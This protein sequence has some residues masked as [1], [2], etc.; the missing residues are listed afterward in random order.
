MLKE[1]TKLKYPIST[2][3][4]IKT[5]EAALTYE[6][7]NGLRYAAG[8]MPRSLKKK[9]YRSSHQHKEVLI[10]LL[11]NLLDKRNDDFTQQI[12]SV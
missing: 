8:Y 12:G 11:R 6:E 2:N 3:I 4:T 7:R 9:L 1:L 10:S 5:E